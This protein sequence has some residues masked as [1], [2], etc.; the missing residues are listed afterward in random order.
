MSSGSKCCWPV[1]GGLA[2]AHERQ[3]SKEVFWV[4]LWRLDLGLWWQG[5]Y[6]L[7]GRKCFL[8]VASPWPLLP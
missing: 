1:C 8:S 7:F 3:G 6:P 2:E 4:L 5:E